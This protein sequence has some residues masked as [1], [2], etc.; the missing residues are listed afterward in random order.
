M[1]QA[2]SRNELDNV[3]LNIELTVNSIIQGVALSFLVSAAQNA[4]IVQRPVTWLYVVAGLLIILLFWVRSLI[5]TL[6]LIRWPLELGHNCLYFAAAFL[7]V[8]AFAHMNNP[9]LWFGFLTLFAVLVWIIF[10]YDLRVVRARL[11]DSASGSGADL[12]PLVMRDQLL[13]IRWIV[14]ALFA[15]NLVA[16]LVIR[17]D[18]RW[19][20]LFISLQAVVLLVYL[21]FIIRS[22]AGLTP[23]IASTR[24]QWRDET[25]R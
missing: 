24:A 6:T 4:E 3:V 13:N 9:A 11:E 16:T 10:V 7:E 20:L 1:N 17:Q 8:L 22:F 19:H 2:Q 5:H 23:L 15:F 18:L 12:Y 21:L 14:P 25:L